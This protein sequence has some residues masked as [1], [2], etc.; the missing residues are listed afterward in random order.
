MSYVPSVPGVP[1]PMS[2]GQ[3]YGNWQQYAGF[4]TTTNPFGGGAGLGVQPNTNIPAT[5]KAPAVPSD[6][7]VPAPDYSFTPP[8]G[9]LGNNPQSSLGLK[10]TAPLGN[11]PQSA[12]Q[13]IKL[14][15]W[16]RI[17]AEGLNLQNTPIALGW[18]PS[19]LLQQAQQRSA[20]SS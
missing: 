1:A 12:V 6:F 14:S 7:N 11:I 10:P 20:R 17:M 13:A 19:P 9:G 3:G 2:Y 18:E 16:S 15:L 5:A 8:T 4:D